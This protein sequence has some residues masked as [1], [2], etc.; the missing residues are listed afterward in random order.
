[1]RL[2]SGIVED[3]GVHSFGGETVTMP[4]QMLATARRRARTAII[5]L[6]V[7]F[8]AAL[9]VLP[10]GTVLALAVLLAGITTMLET[11]HG[12]LAFD[13]LLRRLG[14]LDT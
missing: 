14:P 8:A 4:R 11:M 7:A 3:V 10:E 9:F 13:R 1:M 2:Y 12:A 6:W 5:G